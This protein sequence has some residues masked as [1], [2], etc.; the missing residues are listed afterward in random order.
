MTGGVGRRPDADVLWDLYQVIRHLLAWENAVENGWVNKDGSRNWSEM[1][2]VSYDTPHK[3]GDEPLATMTSV[4]GVYVL[5]V[6]QRQAQL[7]AEAV[8]TSLEISVG[9]FDLAVLWPKSGDQQLI[10]EDKREW[11]KALLEEA[12]L[13]HI[14]IT[15]EERQSIGESPSY[16]DCKAILDQLIDTKVGDL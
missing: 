14:K 4:D 7:I 13:E 5:S 6:S 11:F 1:M 9:Y 3:S 16:N 12:A 2:Q 8:R 10:A 15:R